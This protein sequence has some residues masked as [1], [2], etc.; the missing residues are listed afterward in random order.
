MLYKG[1]I[2]VLPVLTIVDL[3]KGEGNYGKK[4][5]DFPLDFYSSVVGGRMLPPPRDTITV[6]VYLFRDFQTDISWIRYMNPGRRGAS[7]CRR[8]CHPWS[9]ACP[10]D[11]G[12]NPGCPR[13]GF[14]IGTRR[15]Q[16]GSRSIRFRLRSS[17]QDTHLS[18]LSES[19]LP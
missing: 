10:H 2:F 4:G 16:N 17:R 12:Y 5:G 9:S 13:R 11:P 7:S 19:S 1:A 18:A 8:L 6:P 3:R 15:N 14:F